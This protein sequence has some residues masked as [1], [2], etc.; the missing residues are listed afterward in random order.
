MKLMSSRYLLIG[1]L[2]FVTCRT[3]PTLPVAQQTPTATIMATTVPTSTLL[4]TA[5]YD[6]RLRFTPTPTPTLSPTPFPVLDL[7]EGGSVWRCTEGYQCQVYDLEQGTTFR[8]PVPDGCI[9]TFLPYKIKMLCQDTIVDG[10]LYL[11]NLLTEER[12]ELPIR[13]AERYGWSAD[14]QF[15]FY[16]QPEG[17]SEHKTFISYEITSGITHTLATNIHPNEWH[18]DTIKLSAQGK[19]LAVVAKTDQFPNYLTIFQGTT[20]YT[21]P[22]VKEYVIS[23]W[24]IVWSPTSSTQLIFGETDQREAVGTPRSNHFFLLDLEK[25]RFEPLLSTNDVVADSVGDLGY[26]ADTLSFV[27][28]WSPDGTK[29]V[30]RLDAFNDNQFICI[31]SVD[32]RAYD[33]PSITPEKPRNNR[34]YGISRPLWSPQSKQ[35]IFLQKLRVA[36]ESDLAIYDLEAD[37]VVVLLTDEIWTSSAIFWR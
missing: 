18:E 31:I 22:S 6:R 23:P 9:N 12:Q 29:V 26:F 7:V 16:S 33:C 17:D 13:G 3:A 2:F 10:H 25:K 32:S 5:T 11:Y 30:L 20:V 24:D 19:Y 15:L 35:L 21:Q 8:V 37:E 28:S 4:A 36:R 34:T 14:G 1:I 27:S